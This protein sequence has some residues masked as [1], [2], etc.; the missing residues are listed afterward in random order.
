MLEN[1]IAIISGGLGDI[2]SAI[3]REFKRR[4]AKVAIGDVKESGGGGEFDRYD[5]VDVSDADAVK[6]WIA[7]VEK[8]LGTPTLIIA[9]AAIV[10]LKSAMN[11]SPA[12]W[13]KEL[14]INLDGALHMAQ[15]AAA[16]LIDAK[17]P[18]R[19]VFIGSWAAHAPHP[20][21]TTYCVA[22]AGLRMLCK[23]MALE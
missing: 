16:R 5:R 19:I 17:K 2:G 8:S 23:C 6:H 3:A 21:I 14:S 20:N 7:N 9:N 22:K 1:Q 13:R 18:G 4:G 11:I 10:T 12:E 15:A